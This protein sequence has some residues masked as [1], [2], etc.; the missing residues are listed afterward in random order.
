MARRKPAPGRGRRV[1]SAAAL[2]VL[3]AAAFF[4]SFYHPPAELRANVVAT[5]L[6]FVYHPAGQEPTGGPEVALLAGAPFEE[7]SV[8]SFD[9]LTAPS[10]IL[11]VRDAADQPWK[12]VQSSGPLVIASYDRD[13]KAIFPGVTIERWGFDG[14]PTVT[15]EFPGGQAV[16]R[17]LIEGKDIELFFDAGESIEF[18]CQLCRIDGLDQE[19]AAPAREVKLSELNQVALKASS[20]SSMILNAT[21]GPK[22]FGSQRFRISQPWFCGGKGREPE[23]SVLSGAVRFGETG[24]VHDLAGQASANRPAGVLRLVPDDTFSVMALGAVDLNGRSALDVQ[25]DGLAR[26]AEL[27]AACD[28]S[29]APF[30]PSFSEVLAHTPVVAT[31]YAALTILFGWL[32]LYDKVQGLWGR[33]RGKEA[34]K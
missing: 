23:S 4:A 8:R 13:A 15:L 14:Q 21:P 12:V 24:R 7:L 17:A 16:L 32:A 10:A 3:I 20:R 25:F 6:R 19:G 27:S 2:A 9:T 31:P 11:S 22:G 18:E 26:R 34:D 5:A 1:M 28:V 33:M 30:Q 29:G